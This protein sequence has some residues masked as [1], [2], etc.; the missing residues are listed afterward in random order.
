MTTYSCWKYGEE[1]A[2]ELFQQGRV[3]Q[4]T[5]TIGENSDGYISEVVT[6]TDLGPTPW[7]F[8]DIGQE[9]TDV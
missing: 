1:A 4:V 8:Q 2:E 6:V 5:A 3:V 7:P 9:A